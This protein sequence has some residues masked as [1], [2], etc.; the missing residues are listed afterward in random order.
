[1]VTSLELKGPKKQRCLIDI[2]EDTI[3]TIYYTVLDRYREKI[4]PSS[5]F[6]VVVLPLAISISV[7]FGRS[8]LGSQI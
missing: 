2:R 5:F 7:I 8:G 6:L 1:M 4:Q 3:Q